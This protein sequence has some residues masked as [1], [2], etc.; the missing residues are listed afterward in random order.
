M[1]NRPRAILILLAFLAFGNAIRGSFHFDDYSLFATNPPLS[2][3][4]RLETTRP[5]TWLT[6]WINRQLAGDA[7]LSWHLIDFGLHLTNVLLLFACL[8]RIATNRT[9]LVAA[10]IFAIHPIQTEA[11]AYVFARSTLLMTLFCL[12]AWRD[13]LTTHHR[14]AILWFALALLAKEEC[15]FFPIF[16]LLFDRKRREA[17]LMLALSLLAGL[18]TIAATQ[19]VQGSGAGLTAGI[20]PAQY[21]IAQ[22][23][24]IWRY[25]GQIA[26]PLNFTIDP[27][28]HPPFWL[29]ILGWVALIA[30]FRYG[31][32]YVRGG[33]VLLLASSSIFPAAD[34]AA[35][36]RMYLPLIAFALAIAEKLPPRL[37]PILLLLIP[38]S[39]ARTEVWRTER[40]LW[41]DAVAKAPAKTRPRIQLARALPPDHALNQ[42]TADDPDTQAERGRIYLQTNR[43][44]MALAE[45]GKVAAARPKDAQAWNNLGVAF[46]QLEQSAPAR[47]NF[48]KALQLDPC[49]KDARK[50][51]GLPACGR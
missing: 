17:Y 35:D 20:S 13:W 43:A 30:A 28:L 46:A 4:L 9:A 38:L 44:A 36:R 33:I 29:G 10:A 27:D 31:S 42:L 16:L 5:L 47:Q 41:E 22:G 37:A 15:V 24:V 14:R 32:T 39:I 11:V 18:R 50:N 2:D 7:P 25:L 23:A 48:R 45:F 3:L 8:K 19:I 21:A 12:L 26:I 34:L 6:F 40:N 1:F 51:L 49:N